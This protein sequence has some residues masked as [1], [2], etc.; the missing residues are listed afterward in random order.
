M[1]PLINCNSE[2]DASVLAK[3]TT[4]FSND[5]ATQTKR[6]LRGQWLAWDQL[7]PVVTSLAHQLQ[8]SPPPPYVAKP[9]T[10]ERML[11]TELKDVVSSEE[12]FERNMTDALQYLASYLTGDGNVGLTSRYIYGD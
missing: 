12:E 7:S 2:R 11:V 6:G 8:A 10:H 3:I 4:A 1:M 9:I 5:F